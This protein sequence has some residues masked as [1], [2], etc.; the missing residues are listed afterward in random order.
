MLI[1]AFLPEGLTQLAVDSVFMMPQLGVLS[2]VLPDA[3]AE[4][5]ERDCLVRLGAVL[6]P[7][8]TAR[9]GQPCVTVELAPAHGATVTRRVAFGEMV[10]LPMP[11]GP[12]RLHA[13]PERGFD[14][15]LGRGRPLAAEVRGGAAGLIVDARGRPFTLPDEP[16][17]RMARL[18][19]WNAALDVYPGEG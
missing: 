11:D 7:V 4:V 18:R 1:D 15:G 12:A 14:L 10:R 6:A 9:A 17:E 13:S 8:G 2:T 5:F 16:R 3:A 19:T